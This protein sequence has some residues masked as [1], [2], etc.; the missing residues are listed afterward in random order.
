MLQLEI[1]TPVG[2]ALSAQVDSVVVPALEGELQVLA[3]HLPL[4][5]ILGSGALRY[6]DAK[7]GGEALVRGGVLE[8]SPEGRVLV[9][10]D[11]V[12]LP[13][14]LDK[15]RAQRVKDEALKG[16]GQDYLTDAR[17]TQLHQDLRFAEVVL[18][19]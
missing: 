10:T 15:A 17:L 1:V 14:A 5:T 7:G 9:L 8:V 6:Q 4:L 12:Q 13:G 2:T 11:E 19:R 16:F 18:A 3:Q